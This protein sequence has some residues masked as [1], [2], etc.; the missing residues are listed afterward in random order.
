MA[1]PSSGIGAIVVARAA[2]NDRVNLRPAIRSSHGSRRCPASVRSPRVHLS[3]RSMSRVASNGRGQLQVICTRAAGLQLRGK[4]TTRWRDGQRASQV[5][6]LLV[7][8]AWRIRRSITLRTAALQI[9]AQGVAHRRGT[10]VTMVALARRLA[11]TLPRRTLTATQACQRCIGKFWTTREIDRD[12]RRLW[13]DRPFRRCVH[14]AI[15]FCHLARYTGPLVS[16]SRPLTVPCSRARLETRSSDR[17]SRN[18]DS[19]RDFFI[20]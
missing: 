11:R 14:G 16:V 1:L 20:V 12:I 6:S 18:S 7:Q 13:K 9:W 3:R 15:A 4:T 10:K 2:F 17:L 5:Q 19:R 8:A